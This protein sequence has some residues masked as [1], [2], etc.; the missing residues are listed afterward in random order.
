MKRYYTLGHSGLR[1]S[2]L[3]LGT[4]TFG[5]DWGW[6]ADEGSARALFDRYVEAG[7]N[8]IDT[9]DGYTGGKSEEMVGKFVGERGLRDRL[10]VATKFSFNAEP[11][12]PNAGGNGRKNIYRALEGSL[13]RLRTDYVDL[14]QAHHPDPTTPIEETLRAF[15]DL[16]RAGKV[17]YVGVSNFPAHQLSDAIWT[18]RTNGLSPIVSD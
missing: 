4:M 10:V 17:R 9:A 14:Y 13:R 12:N 2:R 8:F 1:V 15:E 16:V 11:G 6:G 7:G 5:T 3:A 18:A